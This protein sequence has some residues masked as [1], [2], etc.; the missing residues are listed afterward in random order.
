[1]AYQHTIYFLSTILALGGAIGPHW[2]E[3]KIFFGLPKLKTFNTSCL[4]VGGGVDYK[5]WIFEAI[6]MMFSTNSN[7]LQKV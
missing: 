7:S 4:N 2:S 1:M 5:I 3:Q 6:Q